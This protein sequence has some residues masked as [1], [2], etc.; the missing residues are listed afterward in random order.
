[1][2]KIRKIILSTI[3]WVLIVQNMFFGFVFAQTED[4]N[5]EDANCVVCGMASLEFQTY[6]N[7]QVEMFQVLQNAVKAPEEAIDNKKVWLFTSRILSLPERLIE[8]WKKMFNKLTQDFSEA[9]K[10]AKIWS[11]MLWTIT[12]ELVGKDALW[13]LAILLR[14]QPFVRD[15][16]TLQELDMTTHDLMWDFGMKWLWDE[17]ISAEISSD[18]EK[19]VKDKYVMNDSNLYWLFEEFNFK[20]D[21]KYKDIIKSLQKLNSVM[22]SFLIFPKKEGKSISSFE[23]EMSKG[24]IIIKFNKKLVDRMYNSYDCAEWMNAC[25]DMRSDF[26]KVINVLPTIKSSFSESMDIIKKANKDFSDAY[27]KS[28]EDND[29]TKKDQEKTWLTEKQITLLRTV[30]GIDTS[31]LT[32]NQWIGLW[33]ILDKNI[34]KNIVNS[35]HIQPLD[36]FSAESIAAKKE[37]QKTR[38]QNRQDQKYLASLMEKNTSIAE[39]EAKREIEA[40]IEKI[41]KILSW[42]VD[43]TSELKNVLNST[44]NSVLSEKS[45]DKQIVMIYD[46]LSTTKYFK[47]IWY[48]IHNWI[49]NQIWTKDIDW[50]VKYLWTVCESQCSNNGTKN[51]YAE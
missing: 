49:D 18:I 10:A 23:R 29:D 48:F 1:M 21:V 33:S 44:L 13:G 19:L 40:E 12:S 22:K 17:K 32:K 20:W 7:F 24:N 6:V 46:S 9:G 8:S 45:E 27:L 47:E 30:Y 16:K 31:K 11:I 37:A 50:L 28:D 34:G 39:T 42:E 3:T 4:N 2:I 26:K 38:K 43:D 14:N 15:W 36:I 5:E 25:N 35:T 41:R 51:C